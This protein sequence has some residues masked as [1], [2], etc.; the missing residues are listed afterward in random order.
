MLFVD[1]AARALA[2]TRPR[3][4]VLRFSS[5][6]RGDQEHLHDILDQAEDARNSRS[7]PS[8]STQCSH[9]QSLTT[10]ALP[11]RRLASAENLHLVLYAPHIFSLHL[12][13]GLKFIRP[14]YWSYQ[15]RFQP[16]NVRTAPPLVAPSRK[17][18]S[19][20]DIFRE[21]GI[22]PLWETS[23]STL[24]ASFVTELGKIRPRTQTRLTTKTQRRLGK[25]IRRAKMMGLIPL[26]YNPRM[27]P[28]PGQLQ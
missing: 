7:I 16:K 2:R 24:L 23:N 9:P 18:A 14:H 15:H 28:K 22:D 4:L 27:M 1:A 13:T 3:L 19:Q 6:L 10:A 20:H 12:L 17:E 8:P 21:L 26:F 5:T 11:G 25:A